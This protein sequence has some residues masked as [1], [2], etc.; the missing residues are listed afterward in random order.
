M[1]PERSQLL[2]S[3]KTN[4]RNLIH[5][6]RSNEDGIGI[7][8]ALSVSFIVFALGATWYSLAVHEL[9]EVSFD[10]NRTQA[11]NVAE[12]G[13][14]EAMALLT[15]DVDSWR[16]DAQSVGF[17]SS[18]IL[19]GGVCDVQT[20][21]TVN[22]GVVEGQGEYWVAVTKVDNL[23]YHVESWGWAPSRTSAKGVAKKVLLDVE[24]VPLGGFT[25]ALFAAKGGIV[26]AN[27]K[28][29]YGDAYSGEDVTISS[30]TNI[31]KNDDPYRGQGTLSV[32][33]DLTI[34]NGSNVF[35]QSDVNVQGRV[36]DLSAS[37][38]YG[39]TVQI[40]SDSTI[41]SYLSSYFKK[42][43]VLGGEVKIADPALK[44][45]SNIGGATLIPNAN[46]MQPVPDVSLPAFTFNAADYPGYTITYYANLTALRAYVAAN[47]NNLKGV[48]VVAAGDGS[49]VNFHQNTFTDNFVL[50]VDGSFEIR[51]TPKKG[52][53]PTGDPASVIIVMK[54]AAGTLTLGQ[55]FQSVPGEVHHLV[56][57]NGIVTST[58]QSVIYGALYGYKD[59]TGNRLEIHFRPPS[60]GVIQGFEFDPALADSFIP[61]PGDWR[62]VSPN[63]EP[64]TA[65]CTP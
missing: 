38:V 16:T 8:T 43:T 6:L 56:F 44:A 25:N 45:G 53:T 63:S 31:Y 1:D 7:I 55:N 10:R 54:N 11:L 33:G 3:E 15:Y 27:F 18:G 13:A 41:S 14:K 61:E 26:G 24:L 47:G 40:R 62:D 28:T 65:Y 59:Q 64:V 17:A 29:I 22:E 35:V 12:A 39:S 49:V 52:S 46:D 9:D 51:G 19:P 5:Q 60:E 50:I 37:T 42:A 36:N 20:L 32:Y 4:M 58:N 34:A 57:S 2:E 23:K 21:E 30:S 48:H